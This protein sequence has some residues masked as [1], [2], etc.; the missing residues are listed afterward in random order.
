MAEETMQPEN[1]K[2]LATSDVTKEATRSG[3]HG[4]TAVGDL[5]GEAMQ[6]EHES[7]ASVFSS[8]KEQDASTFLL[9]INQGSSF[10]EDNAIE[11]GNQV[12]VTAVDCAKEAT[13][14]ANIAMAAGSSSIT[15]RGCYGSEGRRWECFGQH[16]NLQYSC[17][18]RT[19]GL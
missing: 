5:V 8:V 11:S 9:S 14:S 3:D 7:E 17:S 1:Q 15:E 12:F 10:R 18:G 6:S 19:R 2:Y 13:Q 16:K 4:L